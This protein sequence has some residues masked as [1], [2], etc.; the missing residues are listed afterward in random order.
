[1]D[2]THII[3]IVQFAQQFCDVAATSLAKRHAIHKAR[4]DGIGS[5]VLPLEEPHPWCMRLLLRTVDMSALHT[6]PYRLL[7]S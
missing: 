4:P 1:M 3:L 5:S 2:G 7:V 6:G